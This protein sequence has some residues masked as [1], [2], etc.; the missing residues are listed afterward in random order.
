MRRCFIHYILRLRLKL[1]LLVLLMRHLLLVAVRNC[2]IRQTFI[3]L[4]QLLLRVWVLAHVWVLKWLTNVHS[5]LLRHRRWTL[6]LSLILLWVRISLLI[7]NWFTGIYLL[8]NIKFHILRLG[9][10]MLWLLLLH[11]LVLIVVFPCVRLLLLRNII[12]TIIL[13]HILLEL[14][15]F[16]GW[17]LYNIML[18]LP[19]ILWDYKILIIS[20]IWWLFC[21]MPLLFELFLHFI[22]CL[23][24]IFIFPTMHLQFLLVVIF[25]FLF[26]WALRILSL[27]SLLLLLLLLLLLSSFFLLV[28]FFFLH[29]LIFHFI[30]LHFF[31]MPYLLQVFVDFLVFWAFSSVSL[32]Y[33]RRRLFFFVDHL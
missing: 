25:F 30:G 8:I 32:S 21:F 22:S 11:L 13:L 1:H 12:I 14:W 29:Q 27:Y 15:T 24:I 31:L 7:I 33:H 26:I 10:Q 20:L 16:L 28:N 2:R 5:L 4:Y 23:L 3:L 9:L 18:M 17:T 6:H 19:P